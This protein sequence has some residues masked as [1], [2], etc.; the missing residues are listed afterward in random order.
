MSREETQPG[1]LSPTGQRDNSDHMVVCLV[2]KAGKRGESFRV[3]VFVLS[4]HSV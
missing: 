4:H 2:Y 1:V 3:M